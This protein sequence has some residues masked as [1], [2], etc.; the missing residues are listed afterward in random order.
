MRMHYALK[1]KVA[2]QLGNSSKRVLNKTKKVRVL[3]FGTTQSSHVKTNESHQK[4]AYKPSTKKTKSTSKIAKV[5]AKRAVK[6]NKKKAV[7]KNPTVK[8]TVNDNNGPADTTPTTDNS[9]NSA[10][11]AAPATQTTTDTPNTANQSVPGGTVVGTND[12]SANSQQTTQSAADAQNAKLDQE[13]QS[14]N[15]RLQP[16]YTGTAAVAN[17]GQNLYYVTGAVSNVVGQVIATIGTVAQ[18]VSTIRNL[19]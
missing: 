12:Q 4:R 9:G 13:A 17:V 7:K 19:F 10:D 16:W 15:T 14:A 8:R 11:T 2:N 1:H 5:K 3:S 6:K 18:V